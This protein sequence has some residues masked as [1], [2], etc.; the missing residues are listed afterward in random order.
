MQGDRLIFGGYLG[1]LLFVPLP[2]GSNVPFAWSIMVVWSCILGI[3]W[4]LQ[5]LRARVD[6]TSSFRR[7]WPLHLAWILWLLWLV[8]QIFPLPMAWLELLSPRAAQ[9][10]QQAASILGELPTRATISLDRWATQS[11][12]LKT[13]SYVIMFMMSLLL[14]NS[15]QRMALLAWTLVYSGLFQA[16]YGSVAVLGGFG[17][18]L[19]QHDV[20]YPNVAT[21]TFINRNHL[22]GYLVICLSIG[23]GLML[24]M[25]ADEKHANWKAWLRGWLQVFLSPK[26]RLRLYLVVMVIA[27]VMT[28]SRMGNV[29]FFVAMLMAGIV[30]LWAI[31]R[32]RQSMIILIVSLIVI[33]IIVVGAWFGVDKVVQRLQQT[34]VVK[35]RPPSLAGAPQSRTQITISDAGRELLYRDMQGYWR[36]FWLT[37]SG[38]G[39]FEY[40]YP[41]Y[42]S[43]AMSGHNDHAHNDYL[44]FL[45]ET[46]VPGLALLAFVMLY[47]LWMALGALRQRRSA[48]MRGMAFAALMSITALLIHSA[49]DFN[50]QIPANA[51]TFMVL[52]AIANLSKTLSSHRKSKPS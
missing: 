48:L 32:A 11:A 24:S 13:F 30:S 40:V 14:V 12:I 2:F 4:V 5:Y 34:L 29:S 37:G 10:Q 52:L 7:A 39:S 22:A 3:I 44:E 9:I 21:G 16:L 51:M 33:D 19:L 15:R 26:L 8:M 1:L 42:R 47:S 31:R 6:V 17:N 50:L 20:G 49:V 46:G 41:T 18:F 36:D 23:I 25:L 45:A 35:E 28:H 38:L 43:A 27:L